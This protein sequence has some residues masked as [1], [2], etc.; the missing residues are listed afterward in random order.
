MD[1][2]LFP[3][4]IWFTHIARHL[5][6]TKAATEMGMSRPTLSQGLKT[7]EEQLGV[8][9]FHRTT[10][11]MSLTEEGQ[12]LYEALQPGLSSIDRAIRGVGQTQGEPAGLIRLNTSRAAARLLI[13]PHLDEFSLRF[14][15]LRL[16]LVMDD[17]LANIVAEGCDAGLRLGESLAEHMV[18]I[19]ITPPM[20]LAVAGSPEYF[21]RYGVPT[22]PKDLLKHRC[23][24]FRLSN[25]GVHGWEFSDPGKSDHEFTVEPQGMLMTNDDE[26][27]IRG[28]LKHVGLV[29]HFEAALR[30]YLRDGSLV[31]VLEAWSTPFPGF[32]VYIPS[33]AQM[34]LKVRALID[35]LVE[36]RSFFAVPD[37]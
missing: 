26:A 20:R 29:Q 6:F 17:G 12:R 22:S 14:P 23:I 1:P 15:Q 13:D 30:P 25:G 5:S 11:D 3:Q 35:F 19:P 32:Y 9:L 36:K 2:S 37:Q 33:R 27:T 7:L 21:R 10:R 31:E 24:G 34:P 16:D 28:A 18:A 4:L 8:R